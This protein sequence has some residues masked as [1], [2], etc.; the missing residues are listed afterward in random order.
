[1]LLALRT[2]RGYAGNV[3]G[4][5]SDLLLL[6]S[7]HCLTEMSDVM[8]ADVVSNQEAEI[9]HASTN[10]QTACGLRCD[11]RVMAADH[12]SSTVQ[13]LIGDSQALG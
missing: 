2:S 1:M 7:V 10:C 13:E 6:F 11:V 5:E 3:V 12:H 9:K 8:S 4:S